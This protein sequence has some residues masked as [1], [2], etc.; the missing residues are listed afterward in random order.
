MAKK[1]LITGSGGFVGKN[2]YKI[3]EKDKNFRVLG[4]G[5]TKKEYVDQV[6]DISDDKMLIQVLKEFNPDE[7]VHSAALSNVEKCETEMDLANKQNILPT[8]ILTEWAEKNDKK[9]IYISTDY[10]YD[11]VNGNFDENDEERPIQYY[12]Q[13]KL[14]SE[15]IIATLKRYIIFRPT[16]VYG[17]DEVGM[18]FFMQLH[19]NQKIGKEMKVPIDQISNPIS[20]LDFSNLIKNALFSDVVG[21]FVSTGNEAMS[22]YDFAIRICEFM[23]WNKTLITPIETKLFGQVAK[24]PLN[25]STVNHKVAIF[26]NINFKSLEH[27]LDII[28]NEITESL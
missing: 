23:N 1:I 20:V 24:R 3:L 11:G 14:I 5:K 12:G 16:V 19:R 7:I 26:F 10:V 4:I 17:W 2:L 18:N 28:K 22:R 8:K 21:K 9:I 25:N 13:T 6:V 15:K 27:N